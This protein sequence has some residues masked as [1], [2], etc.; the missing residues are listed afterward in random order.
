VDAPTSRLL[1]APAGQLVQ[2]DA[3]AT[4]LYVPAAQLVHADVP[5]VRLL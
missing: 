5:V 1:Y 2:A 4:V 3:P